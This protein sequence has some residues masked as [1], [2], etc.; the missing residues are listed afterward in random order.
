MAAQRGLAFGGGVDR[1]QLWANGSLVEA[2]RCGLVGR[3][4]CGVQGWVRGRKKPKKGKERKERKK[5][6]KRPYGRS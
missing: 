4:R 2:V 6:K 1:G 5:E 3:G